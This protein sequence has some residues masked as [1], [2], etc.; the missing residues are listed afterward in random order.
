MG[1]QKEEEE[2][3]DRKA[4]LLE[5]R[6]KAIY[7]LVLLFAAA[8]VV[9]IG[10]L[11]MAWFAMNKN[12]GNGGM[13][14]SFKSN[15]FE[16]Q[17][18]GETIGFSDLYQFLNPKYRSNSGLTTNTSEG[19]QI[20][21]WRMDTGDDE[22]QPGSQGELHFTAIST[23]ANLDNLKYNLH[24][25]AYDAV[26]ETESTTDEHDNVI[27]TQVL[28]ELIPITTE[29]GYLE[30]ELNA[31]DYINHHVMFFTGR[32]GTSKE[33]YEYFGFIDNK[34]LFD[35]TLN[36]GAGTI[37]WIWPNT[38]GQITLETEDSSYINGTPLLYKPEEITILTEG[39]LASLTEEGREEYQEE[40]EKYQEELEIYQSDRAK[41]TTYLKVHD[42]D[43]FS[44]TENYSS[45]IDTMYTNR[46]AGN[47]YRTQF[48]RLSDGYN[49]ADQTI[50]KNV[51]YVLIEMLVNT[52]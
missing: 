43:I 7:N 12:I 49:T 19:G 45:L 42:S 6:K 47:S 1:K 50:G 16:L 9:L 24:V 10:I 8:F 18:S 37:Y 23:G 31:A 27:E 29:E 21:R 52:N 36:N 14:V 46:S 17:V 2:K 28:K 5:E 51:E 39:E 44:G 20:I 3:K 30:V 38:L 4:I 33:D 40:L 25:T 32:H 34:N 13:S 15:G 11:T 26:T 41:M 35:L 48:D 22:L